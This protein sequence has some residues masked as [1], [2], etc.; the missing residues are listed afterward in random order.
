MRVSVCFIR[1]LTRY[2]FPRK[3][4]GGIAYFRFSL[5]PA[6]GFFVGYLQKIMCKAR[7][8]GTQNGNIRLDSVRFLQKYVFTAIDPTKAALIGLHA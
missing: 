8:P 5:S 7:I 4:P 2:R 1:I 6:G 3:P